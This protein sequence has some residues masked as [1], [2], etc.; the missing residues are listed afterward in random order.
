[1]A[2]TLAAARSAAWR[3][4]REFADLKEAVRQQSASR[5]SMHKAVLDRDP[6][7]VREA[8]RAAARGM[9]LPI[10]GRWAARELKDIEAEAAE[11]RVRAEASAALAEAMRGN[12]CDVLEHAIGLVREAGLPTEDITEAEVQL[13]SLRHQ[14]RRRRL[15]E[16]AWREVEKAVDSGSV[17]KLVEVLQRLEASLPPERVAAAQRKIPVMQARG[18]IRRELAAAMKSPV[19]VQQLRHVVFA[20]KRSCLPTAEVAAAEAALQEAEL[21]RKKKA[22]AAATTAEVEHPGSGAEAARATQERTVAVANAP[23]AASHAP[24]AE[25]AAVAAA[26]LRAPETPLE[27]A[28]SSGDRARIQA[29]IVGLKASGLSAREIHRL[30]ARAVAE[31]GCATAAPAAGA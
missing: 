9:L 27:E 25:P 21:A 10:E 12:D 13:F 11:Q 24:A 22:V 20:A 19:D 7:G 26:P 18:D 4:E 14:E 8:V 15:E 1:M 29:A 16:E 3:A 28:V 5:E 6:E 31:L 23:A 2:A 17:E 30:H